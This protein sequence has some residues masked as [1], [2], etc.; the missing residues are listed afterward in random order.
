MTKDNAFH[1]NN[2]SQ[3]DYPVRKRETK[4]EVF[5]MAAVGLKSCSEGWSKYF[6]LRKRDGELDCCS[7]QGLGRQPGKADLTGHPSVV[8]AVEDD[9]NTR[10]ESS[11][12]QT[13]TIYQ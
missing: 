1:N 11:M 6:N 8:S 5:Y 3:R 2:S 7:M 13:K 4:D 12:R 10:K 9:Y